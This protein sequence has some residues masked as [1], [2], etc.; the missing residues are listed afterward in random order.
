MKE[1]LIGLIIALLFLALLAAPG[2]IIGYFV[3]RL[4]KNKSKGNKR[5]NKTSNKTY[6]TNQYQTG[7]TWNEETKLWEHPN[8]ADSEPTQKSQ[9]NEEPKQDPEN[10]SIDYAKSYVRKYLFSKNELYAYKKLKDI[11][12]VKGY[13]VFAK[14]RL[15]DLIEPIKG[16]K[17]YKTLFYK[18]QAKHV[19]F[20]IT[21]KDMYV[22]AIIEL[23]DSSHNQT[24]RKERDEFVN[25]IL[26]SVGY[27][28]I[29]TKYITNDILD[30]V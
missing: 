14:V 12:E 22:R 28:V 17:K 13:I 18:I 2:I 19:D 20:V 25:L 30:L 11:A 29:H 10:E 27:K 1:S 3:I 16:H 7:W 6:Q 24:E 8:S 9:T 26:R 23:D 21:D 4:I 5:N 15:L